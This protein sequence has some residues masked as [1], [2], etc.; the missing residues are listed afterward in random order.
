MNKTVAVFLGLLGLV[1]VAAIA[2]SLYWRP[3]AASQVADDSRIRSYIISHPEVL[4]ESVARFQA[5]R[6]GS[7]DASSSAL[8][9][10]HHAEIFDDARSQTVGNPK[11]DVALVLFFDYRCPYC[12][13]GVDEEKA[14]LQADPNVKII[15][16]EFPILGP[17][18][19]TAARAALASVK[20]GKYPAFHNAMMASHGSFSD[21]E[22]LGMA[23]DAGIDVNRL[24]TDMNGS[25][26]T[27]T[28]QANFNLAKILGINGTP[29][30]IVGDRLVGGV[31]TADDFKTLIAEARAIQPGSTRQ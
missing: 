12:K 28:L 17:Q 29:A 22:I 21:E 20:Q 30:Y 2:L 14:L 7:P 26:V 11:G 25:D 5:V 23:Q 27:D 8:I 4:L 15:Y 3:D 16:K 1:T 9:A 6:Q 24:M 18:S 31:T 19:V 13:Q 10:A